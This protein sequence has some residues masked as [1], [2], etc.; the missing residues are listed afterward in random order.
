MIGGQLGIGTVLTV[1]A[2]CWRDPFL[3][4]LTFYGVGS[5]V[6][7][8]L[9]YKFVLGWWGTDQTRSIG[10]WFGLWGLMGLPCCIAA[11]LLAN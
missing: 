1:L 8:G 6:L 3:N 9:A 11:Y 5:V 4:V 10:C 2:Y 7:C